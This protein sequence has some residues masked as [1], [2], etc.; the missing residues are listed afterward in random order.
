[1]NSF[2]AGINFSSS[3]QLITAIILFIIFASALLINRFN[4]LVLITAGFATWA[5]YAFIIAF[6]FYDYSADF[7]KWASMLLGASY[8]F[9]G[10]GY[11]SVLLSENNRDEKEQKSV[12]N[13]LYTF[14]TLAILISGISIGGFFDILFI[15]FIFGAFYGSIYLKSRAVLSLGA[16]FLVA[17]IIK[18]TS[19]Y[20][21][22]SVGWPIA[23]IGIGFL[24]IGVGYGTFY[25]NKRFISLK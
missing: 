19:K 18:L 14:G 21:V 8:I 13:I 9:I 4:V 2:Q 16:I 5:Y 10:Y 3:T 1:M 20:F 22:D 24:V 23:L 25:L 7:L 11:K 15:A 12:Q 17:H 6:N